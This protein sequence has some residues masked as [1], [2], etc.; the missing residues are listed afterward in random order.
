MITEAFDDRSPAIIEPRINENAPEVAAC[1]VTFSHVIEEA[2]RDHYACGV[3]GSITLPPGPRPFTGSI[4]TAR[5]SPFS[6]R[7]W[8]RPPAW[9]PSRIP[10]P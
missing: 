8:A 4:I 6:E 2:V 9:A 10:S 7:M 3:L 1:I 5:P